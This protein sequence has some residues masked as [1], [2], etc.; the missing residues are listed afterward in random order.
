VYEAD[1]VSQFVEKVPGIFRDP[2]FGLLSLLPDS[3]KKKN[4]TVKL[5]R[6]SENVALPPTLF[7]HRWRTYYNGEGLKGLLTDHLIDYLKIDDLYGDILQFNL[8]A[9][10]PD[11]LSRSLYSDYQ[12]V[13]DFYFRRNDLNR[14]FQFRTHFPLLDY[15][16]VEYCATIPS[17]LKINGWFDT[18]Y[19]LKKA[20]E[21]VLPH[22]S[23]YRTDKLGHSIPLKNWMRDNREV[24]D[25][26]LDYISEETVRKRGFFRGTEINKMIREHMEK[27]RNN[28]HRL[29]SLAVLEMWLQEHYDQ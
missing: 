27:K 19:I 14:V 2:F 29:W 17:T 6:F 21:K 16:L 8:E 23:V 1:K 20:L 24:K 15:R 10:G 7:S 12:T 25:F 13:V 11:I 9:D 3:D 28:S 5:K 22:T 26:I 18:K 4:I